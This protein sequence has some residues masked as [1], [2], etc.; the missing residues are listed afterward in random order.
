MCVPVQDALDRLNLWVFSEVQE[1]LCITQLA[2][3][4]RSTQLAWPPSFSQTKIA[5][6]LVQLVIF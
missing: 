4:Q 3:T 5:V 2:C 1:S 6:A